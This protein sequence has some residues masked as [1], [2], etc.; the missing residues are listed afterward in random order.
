MVRDERYDVRIGDEACA[1]SRL[2]QPLAA[3]E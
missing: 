1:S 3:D 2:A